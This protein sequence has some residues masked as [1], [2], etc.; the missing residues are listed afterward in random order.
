MASRQ[1][2]TERR[3]AKRRENQRE[4]RIRAVQR[5]Q[6]LTKD[7]HPVHACVVNRY[8]QENGEASILLARRVAPGR[9]T[10]AAFL[11]DIFAMGLKDAWGRTDIGVSEFSESVSRFDEGLETCPFEVETARHLVFGGIELAHRLG[12]RLPHRYERWTALLGPLPEGESPDMDLFLPGGKIRLI[13]SQRDLEAR[14]I[15]TTPKAFLTR[16]DVD[17]IMGDD[18]FT[19][20][21]DEED[22]ADEMMEHFEETM[23]EAARRWCFAHGQ[24]PHPRLPDVIGASLEAISQGAASRLDPNDETIEAL[25]EEEQERIAEQT[26]SF[27]AASFADDPEGLMA[28]A[29]QCFAFMESMGSPEELIAAVGLHDE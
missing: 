8:W 2:K 19:L 4:G 28:A 21:D 6:E 12:F 10:M 7:T 18:D 9:V 17:F 14:L 22:Q 13:C 29:E 5:K 11:V 1:R 16:P 24:A 26:M 23:L 15:G 27:L 20:V 3:R 25:P